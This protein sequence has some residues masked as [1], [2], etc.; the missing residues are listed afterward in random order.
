MHMKRS[1]EWKGVQGAMARRGGGKARMVQGQKKGQGQGKQARVGKP[2]QWVKREE[3]AWCVQILSVDCPLCAAQQ[4]D[5]LVNWM[6]ALA[7]ACFHTHHTIL[8]LLTTTTVI[9]IIGAAVFCD[10]V[11]E[12]LHIARCKHE[13]HNG[14]KGKHSSRDEKHQPERKRMKTTE[15]E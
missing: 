11:V 10:W 14:S 9:A 3:D 8:L 4:W 7:L 2:N 5:T 1:L 6:P 12:G 13:E 15:V